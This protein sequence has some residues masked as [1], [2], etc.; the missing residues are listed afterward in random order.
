MIARFARSYAICQRRS[1]KIELL[2]SHFSLPT[3]HF[4]LHTS[5]C[6]PSPPGFGGGEGAG[7]MRGLARWAVWC[8]IWVER[9]MMEAFPP[10]PPNPL[11]RSAGEGELCIVNACGYR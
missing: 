3:S 4:S 2:T 10:S 1:I 11:S 6:S 8:A 5:L 9:L 7:G